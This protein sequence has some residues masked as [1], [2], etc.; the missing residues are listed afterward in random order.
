MRRHGRGKRTCRVRRGNAV[1]REEMV[2]LE[3]VC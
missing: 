3:M 2:N 1:L